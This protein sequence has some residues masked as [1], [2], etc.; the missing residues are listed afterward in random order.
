MADL[1]TT[2]KET[3][4]VG[5]TNDQICQLMMRAL[6]HRLYVPKN[7]YYLAF[8]HFKHCVKTNNS[9]WNQFVNST[10]MSL[11]SVNNK[12]ISWALQVSPNWT[13]RFTKK[14]HRNKGYASKAVKA[15]HGN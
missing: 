11:I 8:D 10:K 9:S 5:K 6:K 13:W 12:P 2:Y 1:S 14:A 7:H 3:I 15:L 4:T